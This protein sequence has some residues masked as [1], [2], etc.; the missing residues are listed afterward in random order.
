LNF[1]INRLSSKNIIYVSAVLILSVL[2][3]CALISQAR[4]LSPEVKLEKDGSIVAGQVPLKQRSLRSQVLEGEEPAA[5]EES[6]AVAIE[7]VNIE[8]ISAV[9]GWHGTFAV[10]VLFGSIALWVHLRFVRPQTWFREWQK[11]FGS[12]GDGFGEQKDSEAY[13]DENDITGSLTLVPGEAVFFNEEVAL[14]FGGVF[15][16]CSK[17]SVT[18]LRIIAQKTDTT[19]CGTCMVRPRSLV[20]HQS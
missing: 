7:E 15:G 20:G 14:S 10:I 6:T 3:V 18:N 12:V 9:F 17:L 5:A 11:T 1:L 2:A 19:L 4:G 8:N 13:L 16:S